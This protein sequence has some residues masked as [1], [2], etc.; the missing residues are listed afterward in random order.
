MDYIICSWFSQPEVMDK[1]IEKVYLFSW[2]MQILPLFNAAVC[3]FCCCFVST[4]TDVGKLLTS[5]MVD[6]KIAKTTPKL[7][8]KSLA[9]LLKTRKK[10]TRQKNLSFLRI[11]RK[12]T[13]LSLL[14]FLFH[15]WGG[16]LKKN[17]RNLLSFFN[18]SYFPH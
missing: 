15:I 2:H 7:Y 3:S 17:F 1:S 5:T 14:D 6:N 4:K 8:F 10:C 12:K 13:L 9:I 18:W 16:Y 11:V